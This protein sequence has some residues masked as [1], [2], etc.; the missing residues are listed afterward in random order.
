MYNVHIVVALLIGHAASKRL[1][2][3]ILCITC[4]CT[5][6]IYFQH[7]LSGIMILLCGVCEK[8]DRNL[9]SFMKTLINAA[10]L[11]TTI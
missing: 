10:V 9:C 8:G 2:T 11:L 1:F 5:F 7:F 3:V 4:T 6:N